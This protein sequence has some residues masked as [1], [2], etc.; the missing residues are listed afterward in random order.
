MILS[1]QEIRAAVARGDLILDPLPPLEQFSPSAVDL[2]LADQILVWDEELTEPAGV[3][4]VL[5]YDEL[6]IPTLAKY[7][8]DAQ[9]QVDGS[10][11]L[12]PRQFVL[13]QTVEKVGFPMDGGLAARVEGRS[14][15]AR[16]GIVVHLTA[17]TIHADF[18]G[19]TGSTIILEIV[20]L[21]PFSLRLRPGGSR[22]CQLIV[23]QVKGEF[24]TGLKSDF[25][26]QDNPLGGK[27]ASR[28]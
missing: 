21:G 26:D 4:V 23:E 24:D 25:R 17:P 1:D 13:G 12:R 6:S 11:I 2:R 15:L 9:L 14:S 20:N 7:T 16:L 3:D 22:I 10:F 28:A 8:K 18:G 27:P 19:D 5:S